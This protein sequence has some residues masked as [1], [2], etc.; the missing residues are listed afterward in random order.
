[1][2]TGDDG[3]IKI[4]DYVRLVKVFES[5]EYSFVYRFKYFMMAHSH[6]Y[7]K[8]DLDNDT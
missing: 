7:L 8:K 6:S 3:T 2:T 1:M 4:N 5:V